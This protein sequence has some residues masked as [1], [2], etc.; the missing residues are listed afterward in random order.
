MN[1][2]S[3]HIP[4]LLMLV[5]LAQFTASQGVESDISCLRFIKESLE[6]PLQS[7]STWNFNNKSEGFVCGFTSVECWNVTENRVLTIKLANMKLV[8]PF[9]MGVRNCTSMLELD[10]SPNYLS[11]SIPSNLADVLP[12]I[13]SLD[14]SN[15]NISGSLKQQPPNRPNPTRVVYTS[16]PNIF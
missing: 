3:F 14:L 11:G 1:K 7:L 5:I 6:D 9:P 13:L 12:F 2:S 15:N 8:G 4:C 16:T 10:L